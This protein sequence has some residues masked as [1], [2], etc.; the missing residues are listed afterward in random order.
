[1]DSQKQADLY[2]IFVKW[3]SVP[4]KDR[5][6]ASISEF[7]ERYKL[8]ASDIISF[9]DSDSFSRDLHNETMKWAKRKTPELL[10]ILYEQ[11]LVSHSQTDLRLWL[12]A[13][14]YIGTDK[15]NIPPGTTN[16]VNIFNP[17]DEQRKQILERATRRISAPRN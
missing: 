4:K 6:P 10:H 11:Y 9:Q 17:T 7:C 2:R 15:E 16:I 13:V 12:E 5:Q 1:M 8:T 14:K 3:H